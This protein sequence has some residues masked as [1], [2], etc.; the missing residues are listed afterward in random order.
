[1]T[2]HEEFED[3]CIF[4]HGYADEGHEI[5]WRAWQ[6]AT[7][8]AAKV[9]ED[10]ARRA[11]RNRTPAGSMEGDDG[12]QCADAIRGVPAPPDPT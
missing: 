11:G 1:M 9:C 4:Q 3:W 7:E 2:M 12:Y 6:A 8:S 5:E 10:L